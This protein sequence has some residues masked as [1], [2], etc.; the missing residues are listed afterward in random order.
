MKSLPVFLCRVTVLTS[1]PK[2]PRLY[3]G[4]DAGDVVIVDITDK[5]ESDSLNVDLV[6]KSLDSLPAW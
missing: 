6:K 3:V 5:S 2:S 1:S 4:T